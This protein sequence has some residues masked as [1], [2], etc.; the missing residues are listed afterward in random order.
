MQTRTSNQVR[1]PS[2]DVPTTTASWS[3]APVH[4]AVAQTAVSYA[5]CSAPSGVTAGLEPWLN[6]VMPPV[7]PTSEGGMRAGADQVRPWSVERVD[8][9]AGLEQLEPAPEWER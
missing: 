7:N 6:G 2:R 5:T 3:S 8:M 9:G 1:P 4:A